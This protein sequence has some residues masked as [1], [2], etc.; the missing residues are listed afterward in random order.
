MNLNWSYSPETPNLGQNRR[1]FVPCD[2]EIWRM[3]LKNDSSP[4]LIYFKLRASFRSHWWIQIEVSARKPPIWFK[5]GNFVSPVTSKFD[6]WP[7]RSLLLL[8]EPGEISFVHNLLISCRLTSK[9]CME[10]YHWRGV[11][12][13][14]N[15]FDNWNDCCGRTRFHNIWVQNEFGEDVL[16]CISPDVYRGNYFF[17]IYPRWSI[18]NVVI[19]SIKVIDDQLQKRYSKETF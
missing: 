19:W 4:L 1:F 11:C 13:C 3:T 18:V 7:W 14:S 2:L 9:I 15:R 17:V 8:L 6:G 16:Y 5:I 12:K 10:Q